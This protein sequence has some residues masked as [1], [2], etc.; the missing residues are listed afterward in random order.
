MQRILYMFTVIILASMVLMACG[1]KTDNAADSDNRG[2]TSY[3]D[4]PNAEIEELYKRNNCLSCH[5]VGLKG[6]VGPET[7]LETV[8]SRLTKEQIAQQIAK[9]SK[10]MPPYEK[11]MRPEEIDMLAEWLST[12]K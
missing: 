6:R 2:S 9:G 1:Q 4:F 12:Q 3:I 5:G 10:N 8:G 7:N 11:V